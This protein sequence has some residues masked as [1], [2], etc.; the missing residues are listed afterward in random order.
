MPERIIDCCALLNLY[1]GWGGLSE[2]AG[3]DVSWCISKTVFNESEYVREYEPSGNIVVVPLDLKG[4]VKADLLSVITAE[5]KQEFRDYVDFATELDDGEAESL[6][7]AKNRQ[8]VL[9]TDDQ[10]SRRVAQRPDVNVQIIT[11]ASVLQEWEKM[12]RT[13]HKRLKEVISRIRHLARFHPP[14][15]S[16]D[17]AWWDTFDDE[18]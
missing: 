4:P 13:N 8:L 9:L 1:A 2:L 12:S 5:S 10:K 17:R 18:K 14:P 11:T 7:L 3:F 6:A 16:P 15:G